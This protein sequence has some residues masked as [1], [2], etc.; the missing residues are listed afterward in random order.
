MQGG[1]PGHYL[2]GDG[3]VCGEDKKITSII[4]G[5]NIKTIGKQAFYQ[6]KNLKNITVKS[7]IITKCGA[8]AW[9]KIRKD[10]VFKFPKKCRKQYKK[11]FKS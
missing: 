11:Y 7:E 3:C 6:C 10:A 2:D 9:K 1:R 4:I 5:K 8:K